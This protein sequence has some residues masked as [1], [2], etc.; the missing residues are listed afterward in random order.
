MHAQ[1]LREKVLLIDWWWTLDWQKRSTP[2]LNTSTKR[3][4][5]SSSISLAS[6]CM[7]LPKH[8]QAK[9]GY[10][11]L[12]HATV[13]SSAPQCLESFPPG[14]S[15]KHGMNERTSS[16]LVTERDQRQVFRRQDRDCRLALHWSVLL[17]R[18][19]PSNLAYSCG[20]PFSP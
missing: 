19:V 16:L 12:L 11:G 2:T 6:M 7:A 15:R 5:W 3:L 17:L 8:T 1:Q 10:A 13:C 4:V 18:S 9:V 20:T 14:K